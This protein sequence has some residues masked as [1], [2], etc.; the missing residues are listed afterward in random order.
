MSIQGLL[1]E[2]GVNQ[3]QADHWEVLLSTG[4][5]EAESVDYQ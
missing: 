5:D 2:V 3:R 1:I 4:N